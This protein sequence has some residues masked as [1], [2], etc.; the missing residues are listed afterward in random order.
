MEEAPIGLIL[1]AGKKS[2]HVELL[3]VE[4]SGIRV[5]EY[6]LEM[7]PRDV[8]QAKLHQM[9]HRTQELLSRATSLDEV[10][11]SVPN[12]RRPAP[13]YLITPKR[14]APSNRTKR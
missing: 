2:E 1:C 8:L 6:L 12:K 3:Q 11:V 10:A 7:P 4:Q 9:L 14:S 13:S 5:T